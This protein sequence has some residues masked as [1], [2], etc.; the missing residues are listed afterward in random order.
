MWS[1]R[2]GRRSDLVVVAVHGHGGGDDGDGSRQRVTGELDDASSWLIERLGD[3]DEAADQIARSVNSAGVMRGNNS[4]GSEVLLLRCERD[5][6]IEEAR[7]LRSE[8]DRCLGER[9]A[10]IEEARNLRNGV[11]TSLEKEVEDATM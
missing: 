10:V 1:D 7:N 5:A 4:R 8:M 3:G 6:A 2:V 9:D 11:V